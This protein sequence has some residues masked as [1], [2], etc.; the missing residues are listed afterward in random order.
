MPPL[1]ESVLTTMRLRSRTR[2]G[3][4]CAVCGESVESDDDR[5]RL[6]GMFVHRR[7]ATYRTRR[8]ARGARRV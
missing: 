3:R 8:D 6:R 2:G 5:I 4:H 1:I 7:C